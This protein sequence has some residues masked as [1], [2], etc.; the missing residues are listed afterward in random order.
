MSDS[1]QERYLV[2]Y[3]LAA[4]KQ[5]SFIQPSLIEHSRQRG[6]DLV[7][8]DPTKSLLEQ[9]KLDCIIHKLYDVY[10]KENLHEFREK[11]P[12]VPVIDL[13]EAIERLHNR[14]SML[15]VITQLRFPV[16]DSERFGVPEQVVVMDSSVLSG[17]GALGELKFP[18]IAKPLDADGSA[19]S[20]KMFLIYD[21]EGM[22]ILKAPIVLQEFVNHGGVIFKVYVVGDHVKCVKRRSLPDISEEKIGTSK[23]SLPFSQISNLTAQEDKNIEYG[24]DRSLE[25]VEMPPLSFLTDLAKAMR[26][27]MGLNLFNF[28]VIRDA[29]DANR[30]LIIDINYFPGYAKMPSYEPVLTEFFWDMVTKKNHV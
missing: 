27:S 7:K 5:H 3:A 16:S 4:K 1:I 21:Q 30:Y 26:E 2:G 18:V 29:K 13:P 10:W 23:G 22:K 14:V 28:D 6:I 9:G 25:K 11:C 15:E 19:K 24:E 20:H 8:L 12:G 17:G